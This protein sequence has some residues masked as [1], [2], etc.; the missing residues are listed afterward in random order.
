MWLMPCLLLLC[1]CEPKVNF[2]SILSVDEERR[3]V[4]E[5][6]DPGMC[7]ELKGDNKEKTQTRQDRCYEE[8]AIAA[9]KADICLKI[10][11]GVRKNNCLK[12]LAKEAR[13]ESIL[14]LLIMN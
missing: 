12:T 8:V 13:D 5:A 6:Q 2:D 1:A 11:D 4:V 10:A 9:K 7:V 3:R 14:R